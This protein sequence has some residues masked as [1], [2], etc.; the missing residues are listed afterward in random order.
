MA[1]MAWVTFTEV[2][3]GE[4]R[5]YHQTSSDQF[6]QSGTGS[7]QSHSDDALLATNSYITVSQG[8]LWPSHQSP[9]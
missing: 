4:A 2:R 7:V 6:S 9:H 1:L 3:G 8:N 5:C